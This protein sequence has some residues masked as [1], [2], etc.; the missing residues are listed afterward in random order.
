MYSSFHTYFFLLYESSALPDVNL[1]T[2]KKQR[3]AISKQ[4]K[5]TLWRVALIAL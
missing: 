5:N 1:C 4:Q 2:K 3:G